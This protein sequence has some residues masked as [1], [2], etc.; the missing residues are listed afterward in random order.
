MTIRRALNLLDARGWAPRKSAIR[1][2]QYRMQTVSIERPGRVWALEG[3]CV[4]VIG[5][6]NEKLVLML[7]IGARLP[8]MII[9]VKCYV[10][11]CGRDLEK[12]NGL[13]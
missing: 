11:A 7:M 13:Y 2:R 12:L 5:L 6:E 10:E 1:G 4:V 8:I 9:E 3:G